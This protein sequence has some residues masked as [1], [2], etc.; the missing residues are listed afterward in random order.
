MSWR[1]INLSYA[2]CSRNGG[3]RAVLEDRRNGRT[4]GGHQMS[5]GGSDVSERTQPLVQRRRVRNE[6]RAAR[7]AVAL[8]QEQ[9]AVAMDWSLSKVIRIEN[10]STG[11]STND[12]KALL[13]LYEVTD[14][15]E[16]SELVA[17]ARDARERSWWRQY[18]DLVGP[19]FVQF[20]EY[21]ASASA[22]RSFEP[23]LVP[24]LLQTPEYARNVISE[25]IDDPTPERVDALVHLRM[26]RQELLSRPDRPM[27]RQI[28][29]ESVVRRV[30]G[31][32]EVMQ[33]QLRYLVE[34]AARPNVTIEILPFSAGVHN[35][36]TRPFVLLEFPDASDSSV[37][38]LENV[39]GELM[40]RDVPETI[41]QYEDAFEGLRKLTL[42][43]SDSVKFLRE[44]ARLS[45]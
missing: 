39:D 32:R 37:L 7:Q 29:D 17:L 30:V 24:G 18:R 10:G 36:M 2:Q 23:L 20:I 44:L 4:D 27:L 1:Q 45:R 28:I 31:N 33:R 26:K 6:L 15:A 41:E 13:R 19:R 38:Y 16:V 43:P 34:L 40:V 5:K 35:G 9:V 11:I 3:L 21:E 22:I 14:A 8:T 12:L 25:F 42:G